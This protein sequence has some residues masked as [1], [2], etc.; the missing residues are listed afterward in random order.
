MFQAY[1]CTT[2][3]GASGVMLPMDPYVNPL[4]HR[5]LAVMERRHFGARRRGRGRDGGE[6][7]DVL[8]AGLQVLKVLG[9]FYGVAKCLATLLNGGQG[10]G[11]G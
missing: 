5:F 3:R 10:H 4:H 7:R 1:V 6:H 11:R 8:M 9:T 2:C